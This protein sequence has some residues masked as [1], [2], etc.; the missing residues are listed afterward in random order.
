M[1]EIAL[2]EWNGPGDVSVLARSDD[3][4]LLERV[5]TDL[6]AIERRRLSRLEGAL[7][8]IEPTSESPE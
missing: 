4:K 3:A 1:R 5:T 6:A 7:R 8:L 2:I